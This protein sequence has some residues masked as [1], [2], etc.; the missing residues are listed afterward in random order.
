MRLRAGERINM[1]YA[2][3]VVEN[4]HQEVSRQRTAIAEVQ[5]NLRW[6]INVL[7]MLA[8]RA[9]GVQLPTRRSVPLNLVVKILLELLKVTGDMAG[10]KPFHERD[11]KA[12]TN[13]L[14]GNHTRLKALLIRSVSNMLSKKSKCL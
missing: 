11:T 13:W 12:L 6:A 5:C 9:K 4:D 3:K 7:G 8:G 2:L 14:H 1:I 10:V